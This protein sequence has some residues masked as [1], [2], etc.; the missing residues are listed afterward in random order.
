VNTSDP[1]Q[2]LIDVDTERAVCGAV[3]ID[4]DQ[5]LSLAG[6]L[7]PADFANERLRW[8]YEAALELYRQ[9]QPIDQVTMCA[10]LERSK[11]LREVGGAPFL[12]ELVLATP[13]AYHAQSYGETLVRL[14]TL[15]GLVDVAGQIAKIAYGA[16]GQG[17][18]QVRKLV[19]GVTPTTST[20]E[21]LLWLDSLERFVHAQLARNNAQADAEAGKPRK[22]LDLP[23]QRTL[24]RFRLKLR[25]G[26]LA[27]VVAGSSIGKTTFMECCSEHWARQGHRVVFFHLE[28]SHQM[29]LDRRMCR[30]SGVPIEE[31]EAG[32]LNDQRLIDAQNALKLYRGGITYVHC[33]GWSARQITAKARELHAKGLCD[34]IVIDYLQK[35]R[36]YSPHGY[37]KNDGLADATEVLKICTEQLGIGAMAGSQTNRRADDAMRVTAAHIRGSGEV[38]EKANITI[39]LDRDILGVSI[40]GGKYKAGERSPVLD[41]RIDKNTMG[42][43]GEC[44]LAIQGERFL[45]TELE[46]NREER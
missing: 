39:T 5:L 3:L 19:D 23:W 33:P 35:M 29:M 20:D 21:V 30:L 7:Q 10:Q 12:S 37:T 43:T 17:L 42:P 41:V 40:N 31:I 2:R 1:R 9:Q 46:R 34:V 8:V 25:S 13:T 11:R 15:R 4:P 24:G 38:D 32:A 6:T 44:Q 27:L 28:L 16:N 36:L 45:I 14:S 26:T 22:I 18:E